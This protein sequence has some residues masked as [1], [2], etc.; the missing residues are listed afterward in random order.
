MHLQ[1]R[2]YFK[3]N[4]TKLKGQKNENIVGKENKIVFNFIGDK[5]QNTIE[6]NK[7]T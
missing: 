4:T 7:F 1:T 6:V 5:M 2:L 3:L